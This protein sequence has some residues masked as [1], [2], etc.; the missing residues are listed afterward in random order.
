MPIQ[1]LVLEPVT[2]ILTILRYPPSMAPTSQI[3]LPKTSVS[4]IGNGVPLLTASPVSLVSGVRTCQPTNVHASARP[5]V[6][7]SVCLSIRLS[8]RLFVRPSIRPSVKPSARRQAPV[9][10]S[11][12]MTCDRKVELCGWESAYLHKQAK[13]GDCALGRKSTRGMNL[14]VGRSCHIYRPYPLRERLCSEEC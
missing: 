12:T 8:V 9:C 2:L 7:L 1:S 10:H 11:P 6:H 14:S 13:H 5:S 4:V 3:A